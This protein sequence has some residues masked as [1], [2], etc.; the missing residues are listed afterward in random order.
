[1]NNKVFEKPVEGVYIQ[2][3]KNG[4]VVQKYVPLSQVFIKG[5]VT[6]GEHLGVVQ[7][8]IDALNKETKAL[9]EKFNTLEANEKRLE[10]AFTETI[11][12]FV[13]KWKN[14]S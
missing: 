5:K 4:K 2:E 3:F 12:G 14:Q 10:N 8:Q 6:L 11:R 7:A 9:N 1:M 13:T